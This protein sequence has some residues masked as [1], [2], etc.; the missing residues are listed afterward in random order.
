[1]RGGGAS[2]QGSG[3]FVGCWELG[4]AADQ[5]LTCL[6]QVLLSGRGAIARSML[7]SADARAARSWCAWRTT[8]ASASRANLACC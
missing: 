2:G 1:M 7:H 6:F 5:T 4:K 3:S 8:T